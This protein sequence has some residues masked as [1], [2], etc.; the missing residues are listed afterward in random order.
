M[1]PKLKLKGM[2]LIGKTISAL[3]RMKKPEF[4][5]CGWL[6]LDFT[7][8]TSCVISAGSGAWTGDSEEEYPTS[9][10]ISEYIEGLIPAED[11]NLYVE[12]D[13]SCF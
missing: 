13:N 10:E 11:Q 2:H 1:K 12:P 3:T 6:K 7:D 4:D 9:I 8:G 5:D